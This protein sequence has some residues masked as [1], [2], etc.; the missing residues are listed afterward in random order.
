M[1]PAD[2]ERTLVDQV[3]SSTAALA[4]SWALDAG[5]SLS[6]LWIAR[7]PDSGNEHKRVL[8]VPSE[9]YSEALIRQSFSRN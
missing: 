7:Y 5:E 4:I 3:G 6:A 1:N 2:L 9:E 8:G